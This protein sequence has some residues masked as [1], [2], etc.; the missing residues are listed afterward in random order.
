MIND[1]C[2]HISDGLEEE[3]QHKY[4]RLHKI[5]AHDTSKMSVWVYTDYAL[6]L[7]K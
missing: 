6:S 3:K 1:A 5:N 4:V 2:I 7:Y